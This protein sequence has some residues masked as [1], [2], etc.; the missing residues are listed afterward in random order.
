[1]TYIDSETENE[2]ESII[3]D[4]DDEIYEEDCDFLDADKGDR[5]YYIGLSGYV[6]RQNQTIL[7]SSI[8]SKTFMRHDGDDVLQY[9]VDYSAVDVL[10][11][12]A[13][14]SIQILQLHI[15]GKHTYNVVNKTF[16][17]KMVQRSWKRVYAQRQSVINTRKNPLSLIQRQCTGKWNNRLPSIRGMV[18][19][20][21]D[22]PN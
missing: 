10:N 11:H 15:D 20:S 3:M 5:M 16:W 17:L 18:K 22:S 8:S 13:T 6:K 12:N 21:R 14:P 1:M 9:L 7:L 4:E 19:N 2:N